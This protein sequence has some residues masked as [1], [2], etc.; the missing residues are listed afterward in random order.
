[1]SGEVGGDVALVAKAVKRNRLGRFTEHG[2]EKNQSTGK[3]NR[4]QALQVTPATQ[5]S[6]S[7]EKGGYL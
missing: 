3:Q 4:R 5:S 6:L 2:E 7:E 1:M